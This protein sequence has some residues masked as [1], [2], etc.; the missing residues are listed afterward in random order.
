VKVELELDRG[1]HWKALQRAI[2][3]AK[4]LWVFE[5]HGKKTPIAKYVYVWAAPFRVTADYH[6]KHNRRGSEVQTFSRGNMS[7][8]MSIRS[9]S[10]G[11]ST[12]V[13]FTNQRDGFF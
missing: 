5:N 2:A 8:E 6:F 13:R 12:A 4:T 10:V 7:A 1:E 11:T 9:V 3:R